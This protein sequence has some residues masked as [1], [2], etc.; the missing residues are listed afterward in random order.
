MKIRKNR[1][2]KKARKDLF[3]SESAAATVIAAVLLLSIIFSIF[4]VV[5]VAYVPEWKNDAEK[6]HMSEVQTDMTELKSMADTITLLQS[7]NSNSS[8]EKYS[9]TSSPATIPINMG[10]GEIPILEPSKSSGTLSINTENFTMII[11]PKNSL[12]EIMIHGGITYSSNNRQYVDQILRY[13]NGALILNQNDRSVMK[14][15]PSFNITKDGEYYNVFIRAISVIGDR[16]TTS[17]D[18]DVSLTLT[19]SGLDSKNIDPE[20]N[21]FTCTIFTKYPDAWISFLKSKAE[22]AGLGCHFT[23]EETNG[24]ST[25]RFYFYTKDPTH[26]FRFYINESSLKTELGSGSSLDYTTHTSNKG[27]SLPDAKFS[28]NVSQ[29]YVPLAVQFNDSSENAT[30]WIWDFGDGSKNSY[31]QNPT[32]TYSKE[33]NYTVTLLASNVN[34]TDSKDST[35]NVSKL[36]PTITW[37]NPANITYGTPLSETQLNASASTPGN[38]IYRPAAGTLLGVGT[39]T[40]HVDF[41]PTDSVNYTNNSMDVTINVLRATPLIIWSK[42]DDIFYRTALNSTQLNALASVNG[43]FVYTPAAGTILNAGTHTLHADFT[44]DDTANYTNASKNVTINVL[45]AYAYITN[46]GSNTVSIIDMATNNIIATITVG[47][48][49]AGIAVAPDGTKVYVTNS[50]TTGTVSVIDTATNTVMDEINVGNSPWGI[51]VNPAGTKLYV[52]HQAGSKDLYVINL[53]N[54]NSYNKIT[55]GTNPTGVAVTPDGTKVYVTNSGRINTP[56]KTVS[57]INTS[58]NTVAASVTVGNFPFGVAINPAGT[59]AYVTNAGSNTVSVIDITNNTVTATVTVGNW[60][61]GIAIN[62]EGTKAY[63]TNYDSNSVSVINTATNTV[64]TTVNVGISPTGVAINKE[65]TKVYVANSGDN[66]VSVINTATNTVTATL[67]V[68]DSPIAFGQFIV[69]PP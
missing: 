21:Y 11:D 52:A 62:E 6:L 50:G 9:L 64:I 3:H 16:D 10:G 63:I 46:S 36:T 28:S 54:N 48:S 40:L 66:T 43:T 68:G 22:K 30:E 55:V 32:H 53:T 56:G 33:G 4:V 23:I 24:V 34:G 12:D 13:E 8:I 51:A 14:Q 35:I 65:G 26:H 19:L 18:N 42:P 27:S 59:K 58:S 44:P 1:D 57:V 41:T 20:K 38:Y 25:V 15:P 5:R 47:D 60:P 61:E 49:P 67:N 7:L 17:S 45:K 31:D 2:K 29:G 69:H 37:S 39:H